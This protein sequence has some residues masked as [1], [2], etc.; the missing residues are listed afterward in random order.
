MTIDHSRARRAL[1]RTSLLAGTAL[2]GTSAGKCPFTV[3]TRPIRRR[4]QGLPNFVTTRGGEYCF[5]PSLS[6]LRWL[7]ALNS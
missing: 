1:L 6:A 3:P 5:A 2:V 7:S 4:F